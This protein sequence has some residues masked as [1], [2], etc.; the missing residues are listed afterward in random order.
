MSERP[1]ILWGM[2]GSVATIRAPILARLLLEVGEVQ[3]VVTERSR[4]FLDPLP[5]EILVHTDASEW[6][7]WRALGDPV[8]HI[9]LRRWADCLLIAP[10][11]ANS[12]AKMAGGLCDNLLLSVARAWDYSKPLLVAPAMNTLMWDH[13]VTAKQIATLIEWGARVIE[14]VEKK[15]ACAD[16][17]LGALAPAEEIAAQVSRAL[18]LAGEALPSF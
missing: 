16:V 14:P 17:G 10:L 8:L 12:L 15:L 7:A 13:P 5:E 9:E 3:A 11:S 1:R 2:T 18:G 6:L 4:H